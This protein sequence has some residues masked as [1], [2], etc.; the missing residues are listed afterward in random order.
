MTDI[1]I[2]QRDHLCI[3]TLNRPSRL[4]AITHAMYDALREALQ[5][6][7][8][9]G[10]VRVVVI[11][12]S[13][14]NFSAGN[15]MAD[16]LN[17]P[18]TGKDSPVGRFLDELATFPKPIVAAVEGVAIGVG[19]TL[20]LHCDLVYVAAS[21]K[22]KL[23]FVSLGVCPEAGSGLILPALMGHQRAA[24]ILLLGDTVSGEKAVEVGLANSLEED[25]VAK[26]LAQA[27]RLA[28]QP[29][30]ALRLTKQLMKAGHLPAIQAQLATEGEHFFKRLA[31]EEAKEALNAFAEKRQPDFSRF[32]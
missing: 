12:G 2:T 22:L 18:P 5:T 3:I 31:S 13:E 28:A 27:E 11:K 8:E 25:C 21:A 23:P 16:F 20:L 15:D 19:T 14:G 30:S 1:D 10:A 9:D 6:A 26:A 7:R 17:N 29:P 4:N 24:E 32:E